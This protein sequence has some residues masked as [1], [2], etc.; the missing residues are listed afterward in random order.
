MIEV[1]P[2]A[3]RILDMLKWHPKMNLEECQVTYLHRGHGSNLKTIP[4][5][6]IQRLEGGF[7][8]MFDGSMVPYHR[9]IKIECDNNI[10]WK[11]SSK[12]RGGLHD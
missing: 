6:D 10:I 8:I 1:G 3:R 5:T 9:V 7:M 12:K 2:L 4:A 11:K